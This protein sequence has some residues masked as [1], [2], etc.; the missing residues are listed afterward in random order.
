MGFSQGILV[1]SRLNYYTDETE[2]ELLLRF[3]ASWR[4]RDLSLEMLLRNTRLLL[5]YPINVQEIVTIPFSMIRVPIGSHEA[6]LI[7]RRNGSVIDTLYFPIILRKPKHNAVKIDRASSGLV[8]DGLPF[9]PVGF[10]CYWPVQSGLPEAEVVR[11]FNMISPYQPNDERTRH[12]RRAY[13]DRCAELGM[14]VHYHL[15]SV[16][17]GGGVDAMGQTFTPDE[18][19]RM[20]LEEIRTFRDHPALLAWYIADEPIA[21]GLPPDSLEKVVQ[22]IRQ[23]DPYHP[24]SMVFNYTR[25]AA[26]YKDVLDI[27]MA[28]PYP[29]PERPVTEIGSVIQRLKNEFDDG[30]PVWIVPQ[31]F[32]GSEWWKREPTAREIRSMTM[33]AVVEGATGVQF[34]VRHGPN[35]FPK[36][37]DAWDEAGALARELSEFTPFILSPEPRLQVRSASQNIRSTAWRLEDQVLLLAVNTTAEPENNRFQISGISTGQIDH[38]FEQRMTM[39]TKGSFRDFIDG[40]DSRAYLIH[41]PNETETDELPNPIVNSG[42][43]EIYSAGTPTGC[44]ARLPGDPGSTY[45]VDS[46]VAR[47]GRHS[48]RLITPKDHQGVT[49]SFYPVDI[50]QGGSYCIS[51]WAKAAKPNEDA[52]IDGIARFFQKLFP[53]KKR[54]PKMPAFA[55]GVAGMGWE[56]FNLTNEWKQY[57]LP[58]TDDGRRDRVKPWLRLADRGTAWFDGMAMTK[59]P[60]IVTVMDPETHRMQVVL[61]SEMED[62]E[63]RY[64]MDG[65]EP[66]E[67]SKLYQKP[68]FIDS[69]TIIQTAIFRD[70]GCLC[71]AKKEIVFHR[72]LGKSVRYS[73]NFV[74]RYSGGGETALTDGLLAPLQYLDSR[75][76]GFQKNDMDVFVDLGDVQPVSEISV[77]FLQDVPRWIF[78]PLWVEFS[79]SEDG[80]RYESIARIPS[81]ISTRETGPLI[82]NFATQMGDAQ[83]R[84]IR[85]SARNR[86]VCPPWHRGAGGDALLFAD[87]VIVR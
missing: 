44:Y 73:Q 10:Y 57:T 53:G 17:G 28:D 62:V 13:M 75:W 2:G 1:S 21:R 29:I 27:V 7:F 26:R 83:A 25:N 8:V 46:R 41:P 64:T 85:I 49:L 52:P 30:T 36:S 3:P 22:L 42:F 84:Y 47:E 77:Q 58:V 61:H 16:A 69:T 24:I 76:Q 78:L 67:T 59:D 45:F 5:N 39:L 31:A 50:E 71:K 34:F 6:A 48:L 68:F 12:A 51:I 74:K 80:R 55:M 23:E 40:F 32:G 4:G 79:L 72:A 18:K 56:R 65:S 14:K 15:L 9:F 11:G 54:N 20:L 43:E 66:C 19:R 86:G 87:E 70:D 63:I 82:H 37:V 81:P 60:V 33:Q 35:R 38:F